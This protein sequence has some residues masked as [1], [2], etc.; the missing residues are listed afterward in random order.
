MSLSGTDANPGG[1]GPKLLWN[2]S[3][4]VAASVASVRPWKLLRAVM[5]PEAPSRRFSPQRRATLKAP[6]F[7]SAP[8]LEKND[9]QTE[10]VEPLMCPSSSVFL[11]RSSE[12]S[13]ASSP[14]F[15]S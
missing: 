3:W 4:P 6:S 14:R 13:F 1:N 8:E 12:R 2:T 9:F 15:S 11:E 7:D 10:P 5:M